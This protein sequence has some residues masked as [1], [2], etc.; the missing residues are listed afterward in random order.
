MN[1]QGKLILTLLLCLFG[2]FVQAQDLLVTK[3]GDSVNCKITQVAEKYIYFTYSIDEESKSTIIPIERVVSYTRGYFESNTVE[4]YQVDEESAIDPFSELVDSLDRS[5]D[6]EQLSRNRFE[7]SV[8]NTNLR[9]FVGG[10][11]AVRTGSVEQGLPQYIKDYFDELRS[12]YH[13][14]LG[15]DYFFN[16]TNFCIGA[17][18]SRMA[19]SA[20]LND[21]TVIVPFLDGSVRTYTGKIS[22]DY[23]ISNYSTH[24]GMRIV[25]NDEN[26]SKFLFG[27]GIGMM[28]YEDFGHGFNISTLQFE[29]LIYQGRAFSVLLDLGFDIYLAKNLFL[30]IHTDFGLGILDEVEFNGTRV[31]LETPEDLSHVNISLGLSLDI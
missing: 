7:P 21:V 28:T 27:G 29:D 10:G 20:E 23:S 30:N 24:V 19:A 3:R 5:S 14:K 8:I 11:I 25:L 18:Y 31:D 13:I 9:L 2:L 1:V 26:H 12:G 22:S 4:T 16:G 6:L 17:R 15:M